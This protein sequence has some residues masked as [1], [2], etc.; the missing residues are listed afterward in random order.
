[1]AARG[2]AQHG[3]IATSRRAYGAD[4]ARR[5][6]GTRP[7]TAGLSARMR[8]VAQHAARR[9]IADIAGL[10]R[11]PDGF[12][13]VHGDL[14]PWNIVFAGDLAGPIDFSD[15]GWGHLGLDLAASL[16]YLR[17]P[18]AGNVDHRSQYARLHD[19]LLQGYAATCPLPPGVGR[20]IEVYIVAR[21]FTTLEWVLDDW[22]APDH[23]AWGPGFLLGVE[24]VLQAYAAA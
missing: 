2:L 3:A 5:A 17:F 19:S 15:C 10:P 7:R 8:R 1:M 6:Q 21:L 22:P 9:L 20:Q 4:L 11:D 14:H 12:G 13:F 23:R 24:K 16:Q 18:L